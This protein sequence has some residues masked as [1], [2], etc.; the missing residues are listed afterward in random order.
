MARTD[1]HQTKLSQNAKSSHLR[2]DQHL[3][4]GIVKIPVAH[5]LVA[6]IDMDADASL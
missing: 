6:G 4:V 5:T 2:N 3:G 1:L